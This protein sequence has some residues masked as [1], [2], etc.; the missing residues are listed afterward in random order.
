MIDFA[1]LARPKS[2]NTYLVAPAELCR[3]ATPD[4][5]APQFAVS[6]ERLRDA[7]LN[8]MRE[9]PRVSEGPANTD[10]MA[11]DFIETTPLMRFKDDISVR[12]IPLQP[13][14]ATLAIYSRSR[15]GYSD[16]GTNRK[17][18]DAWL[19]ALARRIG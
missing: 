6:A 15:V 3:S 14:R 8:L 4:R 12:F 2:P 17:R 10:P 5:V 11:Y 19:E 1:T 16:M 7:F 18:V 9:A 13:D